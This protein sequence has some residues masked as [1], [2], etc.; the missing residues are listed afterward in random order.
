MGSDIDIPQVLNAHVV[1]KSAPNAV[2]VGRPSPFGNPFSIGKDGTRE[3]VIAKY[4]AWL[5]QNPDFVARA[6]R[7]LKG[8]DLI[9][10]CAP[11][12]CHGHIL[13]DLALG[14]DLPP[15]EA[16]RQRRLL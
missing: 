9:C 15:I 13:R 4:V 5:H 14:R 16:P 2:Y 1:G 3:E 7:E 10:W 11:R 8:R 12:A 6:R